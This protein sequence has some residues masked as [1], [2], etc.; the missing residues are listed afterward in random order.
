MSN[1]FFGNAVFTQDDYLKVQPVVEEM[2]LP[3]IKGVKDKNKT[4]RIQ[5]LNPYVPKADMEFY[6]M[7]KPT[8]KMK[9]QPFVTKARTDAPVTSIPSF[10]VLDGRQ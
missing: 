5:N 7:K 8:K 1:S 4:D 2:K 3:K 9:K 6:D 10:P